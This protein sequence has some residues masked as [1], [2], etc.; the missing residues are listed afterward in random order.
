MHWGLFTRYDVIR[1][2]DQPIPGTPSNLGD[3]NQITV[4]VRYTI[5]YSNRDEVGIHVEYGTNRERG[6]GAAGLDV[7]SSLLY[8]GVDFLY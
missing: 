1:N 4:G 3:Q 6:T 5:A 8:L 7:R 2:K